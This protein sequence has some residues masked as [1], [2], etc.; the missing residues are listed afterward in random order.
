VIT[1]QDATEL[2]ETADRLHAL[3]AELDPGTVLPATAKDLVALGEQIERSGRVLKMMASVVV[4]ESD[5]WKGEGDRSV[6]DWMARTTGASRSQ[7]TRDVTTAKRLRRLPKVAEAARQGTLSPEQTAMI[8]DAAV[9]DPAAQARLV[10]AA[11]DNDVRGLKQECQ[12]TKANADRDP[13]ATRARIHAK[14][15]CRTWTDDEGVG[16]LQLSGPPDSIARMDHA[17]RRRAD[18]TFREARRAGRRERLDAYSFDAAEALLTGDGGGASSPK[19]ADAKILVRVD[20]PALLRGRCLDGETCEIAGMGPIPVSVV[21]EWM[22]N[23]FL[24]AIVTKGTEITKVVHLGR[25]FTAEQRT[26]L[27]WQDPVCAR[28]GCSNRLRLEY[29]HFED[30]A[31]THTTE[32][33]HA[34]RFCHPCHLLKTR[35]WQVSL[36]DDEGQCTFTPPDD[37]P[38]VDQLADN[39]ERAIANRRRGPPRS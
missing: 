16:H 6:E 32:V 34:K 22:D 2:R 3:V 17:V 21:R 8:A 38:L 27:Q 28:K 9:A 23:A 13:E 25:R 35:G 20:Y 31:D 5:V 18:K 37:R 29:D 4:E 24:A 14:R 11:R 7:A 39:V 30:W 36:P 10:D 33:K 1:V 26:A 12:R 15:S 19:G